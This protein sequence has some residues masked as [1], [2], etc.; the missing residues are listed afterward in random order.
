[1]IIITTNPVYQYSIVIMFQK[2]K[3]CF[4]FVFCIVTYFLYHSNIVYLVFSSR[5]H[6]TYTIFMF[7]QSTTTCIYVVLTIF[8]LVFSVNRVFIVSVHV[9]KL[10]A[11]KQNNVRYK[12][13]IIIEITLKDIMVYW[14]LWQINKTLGYTESNNASFAS[15]VI[16]NYI[17]N[18]TLP[19]HVRKIRWTIKH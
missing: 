4:F 16:L 19:H 10:S 7:I 15:L 5:C 14:Q 9:Y 1:M 11:A 8:R 6:K 12:I 3:Y 18:F 17:Q 2:Y 13:I